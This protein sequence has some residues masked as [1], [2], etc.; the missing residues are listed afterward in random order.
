MKSHIDSRMKS[1]ISPDRD[2]EALTP[3]EQGMTAEQRLAHRRK[4]VVL[5]KQQLAERKLKAEEEARRKK[6]AEQEDKGRHKK[7]EF[8][9]SVKPPVRVKK[10]RKKK[11]K[12]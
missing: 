7:F 8:K 1:L 11:A 2:M 9:R 3:L 10:N 4:R 6:S 5:E 12:R